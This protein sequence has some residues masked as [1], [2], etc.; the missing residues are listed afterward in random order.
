MKKKSL[1]LMCSALSAVALTTV[2]CM[3]SGNFSSERT[4]FSIS[5]LGFS[6]VGAEDIQYSAIVNGT[7]S[8]NTSVY[9]GTLENEM[10]KVSK[11]NYIT[12]S[13]DLDSPI[14]G[15][16]SISLSRASSSQG[17][18]YYFYFSFN[19]LTLDNILEGK[20]QDLEF[21][22]MDSGVESSNLITFDV[23]KL[24]HRYFLLLYL[25][26]STNAYFSD[27]SIETP[28]AEEPHRGD[29]SIGIIDDYNDEL[30]N[31]LPSH[32]PFIGNGSYIE[33]ENSE[34]DDAKAIKCIQKESGYSL[35]ESSL[36]NNGYI[37]SKTT[38]EQKYYQKHLANDSYYT[39]VVERQSTYDDLILGTITFVGEESW[40]GKDFVNG[41]IDYSTDVSDRTEI[42]GKLEQ[43]AMENFL[44]GIPLFENDKRVRFS[45]RVSLAANDYITSYGWGLLKEGEL[46]GTLPGVSE[47]QNYLQL[48]QTSNPYYINVWNSIGDQIKDLNKYVSSPLWG[49]RMLNNNAYEYYPVLAKDTVGGNPFR[50]PLHVEPDNQIGKYKTWKV[51]VKTGP[52]EGIK[53]RIASTS[54]HSAF[55]NRLV[56]LEDYEFVYQMLLTYGCNL[57]KGSELASDTVR[58]IKGAHDF[59]IASKGINDNSVLDNLWNQMKSSGEL[60]IS[61]G[62]DSNGS[63]IQIEFVNP[64]DEFTALYTL[65]DNIYSPIPKAFLQ[66]LGSG[67]YTIGAI[68]FGNDSIVA[69][70]LC[71]GPYFL[72]R[73]DDS[74]I[75]FSKNNDWFETSGPDRYKIPGVVY[76]IYY[77]AA[78]D[79][80]YLW[81]KFN[82]GELDYVVF[83]LS[84][85]S[86]F[87]PTK[88][89]RE[90]GDSNYKLNV[91]SCT[92]ERWDE[93]FG[94]NGSVAQSYNS[95]L[96]KPWMSNKNFLK[97]LFW[98]ID[99]D[100]FARSR[101]HNPTINYFSDNYLSDPI[102]GISYNHTQA[103]QN[104]IHSVFGN[105]EY[106]YDYDKAVN[107][108]KIAVDELV[109]QGLLVKGTK[110]NPTNISINITWMFQAEINEYGAVAN[111]FKNAFNDER[112]S[113]GTV[114]LSVNQ[115]AVAEWSYIYTNH[116]LVGKYDIAAG[117][118]TG[119][120]YDPLNFMEAIKS[121]NSSGFTLCWGTDTSKIDPYNPI[122]FDNKVWSF[123]TLWSVGN[124]YST[125]KD[126]KA[127]NPV[128]NNYVQSVSTNNLY[129]GGTIT[130]SFSFED[131][132]LSTQ[133]SID[134]V[135][136]MIPNSGKRA[137]NAQI[138]NGQ[139]VITISSLEGY[140]INEAIVEA[141]NLQKQADKASSEQER[142][143]ILHPFKYQYFELYWYIEVHYSVIVDSEPV[144]EGTSY[145]TRNQ[146]VI[147]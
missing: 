116:I 105:T 13:N 15:I 100:S 67:D 5:K 35:F 36:V 41:C 58:G 20:Y 55:N 101:G 11:N 31:S 19:H 3:N 6:S 66:E 77:Q 135:E 106:G 137:L 136:M 87:D 127:V 92:Q 7:H 81:N 37:H 79:P 107:Y 34:F 83:P 48:S 121:D 133:Y 49:K 111:Y 64:I 82:S 122:E 65:S 108:F 51:Y 125:V 27:L 147:E 57:L 42:L 84:Q 72:E 44:T 2:L 86:K 80:N 16:S 63:F 73:W 30:R 114:I 32:V 113:G 56:Q 138:N 69:N 103:H 50:Y 39:V 126:S 119:N 104:A 26:P 130:I 68:Y 91:N 22:K 53:Y 17:G 97:G 124:K 120:E 33:F 1:I 141:R 62:S 94:L 98:S 112:V 145:T 21:I 89:K 85:L 118:I 45:N 90:P 71:V 117:G 99:R 95:Y 93:L 76:K 132:G 8:V 144:I 75:V 96:C 29:E 123:D 43:N 12:W 142:F 74:K 140:E 46:N 109:K 4:Y 134:S 59:Y 10:V 61:T 70:T 110:D 129:D 143:E 24:D 60:G 9:N 47:Y 52:E 102:N 146:G 23:N 14:R 115:S 54:S 131:L 78:Q 25:A 128:I 28:C 38:L 18:S 139:I 40:L 88:D